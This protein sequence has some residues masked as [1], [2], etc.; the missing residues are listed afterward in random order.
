[1]K[2]MLSAI[3][4]LSAACVCSAQVRYL[5]RRLK[6]GERRICSMAVLPAQVTVMK[7][8]FKGSEGLWEESDRFED[9]LTAL[10]GKSLSFHSA[11][12]SS[13]PSGA[14][15]GPED[16]SALAQIQRSYD[17]VETQMVRSPGGVAKG[18]YTLGDL[19]AGYSPAASADTLVFIRGTGTLPIRYAAITKHNK[20]E[21]RLGF[22]DA[23]S[24][25]VL[26]FVE[27]ECASHAWS[28]AADKLE[29]HVLEALGNMPPSFYSLMGPSAARACGH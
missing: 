12:V 14:G 20:F 18:R 17:G 27:F 22:V 29:A 16:R 26:A 5:H 9:E 1:M 10:I 3:A 8:G 21:G 25:E 28:K 6:R 2:W 13:M 15:L 4:L 11:P 24:G 7:F 23:R 19:V